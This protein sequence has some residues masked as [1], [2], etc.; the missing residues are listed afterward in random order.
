MEGRNNRC[1]FKDDNL[2]CSMVS[3]GFEKGGELAKFDLPAGHKAQVSLFMLVEQQVS[4]E[5][6]GPD[7][8]SSFNTLTDRSL[9]LKGHSIMSTWR[10]H[11]RQSGA[12]RHSTYPYVSHSVEKRKRRLLERAGVKEG[13]RFQMIKSSPWVQ[14]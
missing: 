1:R 2:T 3:T 7:N 11:T 13:P 14:G 5:M 8:L 12:V 6:V 10:T 4:A 9:A